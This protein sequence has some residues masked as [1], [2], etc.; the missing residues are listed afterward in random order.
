MVQGNSFE[1]VVAVKSS[2]RFSFD[3]SGN[4]TSVLWDTFPI[5]IYKNSFGAAAFPFRIKLSKMYTQC[6]FV[7]NVNEATDPTASLINLTTS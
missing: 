6:L 2:A 3:I 1:V 7:T 4:D 5:F